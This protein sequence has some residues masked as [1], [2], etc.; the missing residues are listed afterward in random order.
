V[1]HIVRRKA[2]MPDAKNILVLMTDEQ[3][4]DSLGYAGNGAARTP[5]L[6]LLAERSADF[7]NCSTAYPLCCPARASLWTGLL[8]HNHHV[9]GNWRAIR[10]ELRDDGLVAPFARA[11]YHTIYTGKWHVPGTTPARFAFADTSAIPAVINGRDRGRYIEEYRA[12]ATAQGY[13][14]VPGNIENLTSRD[15]AQ[16]HEPGKAPCGS[17]AIAQEHFLE[18][19]QTTQFLAALERRPTD[20]PF[21]AVCSY[22]AP[23]F[24]MIVPAPYDRLISPESVTL[25]A[26]F[27]AGLAGKPAEVLDSHYHTDTAGLSEHEWRRLVAHYL[28]L[29]ALVDTQ[30][31]RVL[32][33]L[34]ETD[35]LANTIVVFTSDHGDMLGSHGLNQKGFPLHYEETLHVPLLIAHPDLPMG[36]SVDGLVS[37]IDLLPSLAD[38]AGIPLERIIDGRSFAA[39][40]TGNDGAA[41]REFVTA[42]SYQVGG[43]P[44]KQGGGNG[45]YFAADQ[46]DPQRDSINLSIRT[47]THRYIFRWRDHDELYDLVSDP[48]ENHNIVDDPGAR[49]IVAG[50]RQTLA[51]SLQGAFPTVSERLQPVAARSRGV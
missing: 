27:G 35:A 20:R 45:E 36:Q 50:L 40:L 2:S 23:H 30:V 15:L 22:N 28:G 16:L 51:A 12:Y 17:A 38:L 31:G 18:T 14:L 11:G 25:P 44:E 13:D 42:E 26:N 4:W 1:S 46:F 9:F 6:D 8:A 33:Y 32:A 19:W 47:R 29:C 24:P 3:R 41:T 43:E 10:P 39:A 21:F 49:E 7:T 37:L 48:D 34:R 5:H